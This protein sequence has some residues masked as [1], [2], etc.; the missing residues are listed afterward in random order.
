M[1]SSPSLAYPNAPLNT[2]AT[3]SIAG[4]EDEDLMIR[5]AADI[6]SVANRLQSST[7]PT[8]P[9]AGDEQAED[10]FHE[11]RAHLRAH[12]RED[13]DLSRQLFKSPERKSAAK[14]QKLPRHEDRDRAN[15]NAPPTL[16]RHVN[17]AINLS[18]SLS[19]DTLKAH[20]T[21]NN[22]TPGHGGDDP[23][24][25]AVDLHQDKT[26]EYNTWGPVAEEDTERALKRMAMLG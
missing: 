20:G 26:F 6:A 2:P 18:T 8:S 13:S 21:S 14:K 15:S 19:T 25:A 24:H 3:P 1:S 22:A 7:P 9:T 12:V 23:D 17:T 5:T 10:P 16:L 4:D 11:G